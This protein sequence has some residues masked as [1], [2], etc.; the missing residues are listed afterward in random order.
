[1]RISKVSVSGLFGV[2]NHTIP[3][4]SK[5]RIT[6]IHGPNGLGKTVLLKMLDGLFNGRFSALRNIPFTEFKVEFD[7]EAK[8]IIRQQSPATDGGRKGGALSFTSENKSKKHTFNLPRASVDGFPIMQVEEFV[9]FLRRIGP[10]E[11]VDGS[12]GQHLGIDDILD[13]YREEIP[14]RIAKN[15]DMPEWVSQILG[16]VR[17]R[18]IDTNRLRL[19][20]AFDRRRSARNRSS[21]ELTV[22]RYAEELSE[23]IKSKLAESAAM[24]QSL[25]RTFP[26]R[27]VE[28]GPSPDLQDDEI[29]KQL[30]ELE[31]KRTRLKTVGLLDKEEDMAFQVSAQTLD[32][33]TKQVLKVY[34]HDVEKK[35]SIFDDIA[36]KLELF[37]SLLNSRFLYKNVAI[38]KSAG[39]EFSNDAGT[40]ITP[41]DLSSGE[42]HE[43]VLMYELLFK[44][45]KDSLILI[46]EP[47]ISLHVEW[48]EQFLPDLQK[49]TQ[50]SP[51]DVLIAT[52][53]PQIIGVRWDLTEELKGPVVPTSAHS[54]VKKS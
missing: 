42:Q 23:K 6:I 48:Q 5:D 9:P 43:L 30:A 4:K 13:E 17:V 27:L 11:W 46:D 52:H 37:E 1:M 47:E 39:F 31:Q 8:L 33:H 7:D 21:T 51:F 25:D 3:L 34:A 24:S 2:F 16:E 14:F 19:E 35:L 50:L 40:P 53:S 29:R 44:V 54:T 15:N 28:H 12:T 18:L 38:S 26:V 22:L 45:P 10:D 49:I 36:A 20:R 32:T 41:S